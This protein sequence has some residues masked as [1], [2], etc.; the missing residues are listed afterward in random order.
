MQMSG[1]FEN[2]G[3]PP[4]QEEEEVTSTYDKFVSDDEFQESLS[5]NEK[6]IFKAMVI[7]ICQ[8]NS[9]M[10]KDFFKRWMNY[11]KQYANSEENSHKEGQN[12]YFQMMQQ[13]N[14]NIEE[15]KQEESES[16]Q[17]Q[18]K[19]DQQVSENAEVQ[20]ESY[21]CCDKFFQSST[22]ERLEIMSKMKE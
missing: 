10:F 8:A 5:E 22:K 18:M 11:M 20:D 13:M 17:E 9:L 14:S 7:A 3:M 21:M 4:F 12:S 2:M 1:Q 6:L 19:S 15:N 16:P